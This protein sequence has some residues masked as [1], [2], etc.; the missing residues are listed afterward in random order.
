[1][2]KTIILALSLL[3]LTPVLSLPINVDAASDAKANKKAVKQLVGEYVKAVD[4]MKGD[5][6][7]I[8]KRVLLVVGTER[9]A[10]TVGGLISAVK[11][12]LSEPQH[13]IFVD[14]LVLAQSQQM[15]YAKIDVSGAYVS[16]VDLEAQPPAETRGLAVLVLDYEGDTTLPLQVLAN[17]T[18]E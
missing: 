6:E 16:G 3:I 1:M 12:A 18:P 11:L 5:Q 2:R 17:I 9:K 4:K 7:F 15:G 13:S 14:P 8:N 10:T